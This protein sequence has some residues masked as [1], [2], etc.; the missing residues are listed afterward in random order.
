MRQ[1]KLCIGCGE[2]LNE[3]PADDCNYPDDHYDPSE[4]YDNMDDPMFDDIRDRMMFADPG[5]KSALRAETPDN[6]RIHPCPTCKAPNKLTP[7][8]VAAGYQCDRCA[9]RDEGT[10]TGGDY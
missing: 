9:E 6:P 1:A 4:E 8:D 7:A 5:G 10:Y 2:P 3:E